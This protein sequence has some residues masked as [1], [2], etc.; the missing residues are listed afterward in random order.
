ME[1]RQIR[2]ALSVAKERSFTRASTRLSISQSAVSAQIRLL[3]DEIGFPIFWRS[4]RGI[5]LTESGRTFLHEAER[6]VGDLLNL[7]ET[8]RRLRGGGSEALN[9]GMIS[10]TAQ[11]F[12]PRLFCDLPRTVRDNKLRIVIT[13]TRNIFRDLQEEKIDAGIAIE[14]D[15]DRVPSGLVFDRLAIIE[16]ALIVHPKHA[17]AKSKKPVNVSALGAEPIVMNELDVGYGH[18]VRSLFT[19]LGIRPN[20]LAIADN[21]E[22]IKV[23]VQT[24]AGIAILPRTCADQEVSLRQLKVLCLLPECNVPLSLFRRREPLSREKEACLS[25]LGAALRLEHP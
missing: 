20:I 22:T 4:T 15:P 9:L 5:E 18:I 16:M 12:V 2:Y 19:D 21:V 14:S 17:L 3:E 7:S 1:F 11:T 6:I 24:G 10:G 25:A 8:A 13:P 23:I